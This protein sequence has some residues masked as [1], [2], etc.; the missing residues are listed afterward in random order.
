MLCHLKEKEQMCLAEQDRKLVEFE[1]IFIVQQK[2]RQKFYNLKKERNEIHGEMR[3]LSMRCGLLDK[4]NMIADYDRTMQQ[5]EQKSAINNKLRW[6]LNRMNRYLKLYE[7][8]SQSQTMSIRESLRYSLYPNSIA[9]NTLKSFTINSRA[10]SRLPSQQFSDTYSQSL[11]D[12]V[13]P[14]SVVQ[15][16]TNYP[17]TSRN[18]SIKF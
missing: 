3:N 1:Q 7:K 2:L 15:R 16:N 5:I 14:Q 12:L 8:R 17:G 13:N 6:Q 11:I 9:S 4:P 10:S 18:N